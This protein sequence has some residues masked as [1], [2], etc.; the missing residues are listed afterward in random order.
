MVSGSCQR[1]M[2][3]VSGI[4]LW[5]R[6]TGMMVSRGNEKRL[7]RGRRC[8]RRLRKRSWGGYWWSFGLLIII[9]VEMSRR[10]QRLCRRIAKGL[11]F[12]R[13]QK[14]SCL[15]P[16]DLRRFASVQGRA[17][18]SDDSDEKEPRNFPTSCSTHNSTGWPSRWNAIRTK[19]TAV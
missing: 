1:M 17:V 14:P 3:A 12:F 11:L 5:N 10:R 19:S 16:L 4:P 7:E 8:D 13:L 18:L 6:F 15:T 2:S 9:S